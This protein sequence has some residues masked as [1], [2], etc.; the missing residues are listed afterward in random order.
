MEYLAARLD[1]QLTL[2]QI[3]QDNLIGEAHHHQVRGR[4]QVGEGVELPGGVEDELP[5]AQAAGCGAAS[6]Q[7]Y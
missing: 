6:K 2:E 1:R 4:P 7:V 3:C 5:L